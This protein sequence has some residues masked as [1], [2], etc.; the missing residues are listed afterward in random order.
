MIQRHETSEFF[1]SIQLTDEVICWTLS[2]VSPTNAASGYTYVARIPLGAGRAS[3]A[4]HTDRTNVYD[5]GLGEKV[6][7][8]P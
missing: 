7:N 2:L 6:S 1:V 8:L 4:V 3:P 5:K